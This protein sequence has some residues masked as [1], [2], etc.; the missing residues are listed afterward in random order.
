[1]SE[2]GTAAGGSAE[3]AVAPVEGLDTAAM[4][5]WITGLGI[6]ATPPV[7]YERV[8]LGQSNLTFLARDAAGGRWVLRRPPL[9]H[10]LASAHDVAR[11][12]RIIGALQPTDVPVPQVHGLCT[13][14]AVTDVPVMLVSY[15]EGAVV[16]GR[17]DALALDRQV[18]ADLGPAIVDA[19]A[20]I[21]AVDLEATGLADLASH[22]PYAARQLRRWGGQWEA[23]RSRDL[24]ALDDL[25]RR[26]TEHDP[27]GG[28]VVLVHGDCHIRNVI[29]DP[30][31]AQIRAV[32]DWELCTLGDPV[33][34]VGTLL[35]YWPEPGET[36]VPGFDA[37]TVDGFVGRAALVERYAS[38]TGRDVTTVPF[39]HALGLWKV[40]I[41]LEGVR[42]RQLD[43][44]R[45]LTAHGAIPESAVDELVTCAHVVLDD[46]H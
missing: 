17:R 9:G 44:P 8:G 45:N 39:W 21:H 26:L 16:D 15:V 41:I 38:V 23:S 24:P 3:T 19:L 20:A 4:T 37:T 1:M 25:S 29:L 30:A 34:D 32:L 10:I 7:A 43:D 40:A 22:K 13:D 42:R 36:T 31:S 12:H 33:A 27:G 46:A 2:G 18:R 28:E 14:P 11:E 6:G 5:G 35:A